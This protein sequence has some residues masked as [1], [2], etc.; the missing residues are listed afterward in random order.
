M[1]NKLK[2]SASPLEIDL[3]NHTVNEAKK[4]LDYFL[5]SAPPGCVSVFVIHGFSRG[6]AL[7]KMVRGSYR[8]KRVQRKILGLNNGITELLLK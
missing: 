4:L 1:N 6:T 2:N 7:Q 8:H 3:H 5:D